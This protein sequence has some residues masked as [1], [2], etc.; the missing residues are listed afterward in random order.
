MCEN[1]ESFLNMLPKKLGHVPNF[2][3]V[4]LRE[5]WPAIDR[6]QENKAD[7]I[8]ESRQRGLPIV[9]EGTGVWP[10]F[11][12]IGFDHMS[13]VGSNVVKFTVA[14]KNMK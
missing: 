10:L 5:T 8:L 7:D 12:L 13:A 2:G 1:E 11:P 9:R 3:E 14:T 6:V 4:N